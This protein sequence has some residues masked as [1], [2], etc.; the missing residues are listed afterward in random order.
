MRQSFNVEP[1]ARTSVA[2]DSEVG[3]ILA[4]TVGF[5]SIPPL[6]RDSRLRLDVKR[7]ESDVVCDQE[8]QRALFVLNTIGPR[9]RSAWSGLQHSLVKTDKLGESGHSVNG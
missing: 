9:P 6:C 8:N 5:H 2:E 4:A 7:K 3:R 1:E